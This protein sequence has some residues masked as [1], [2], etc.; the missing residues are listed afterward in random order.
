MALSLGREYCSVVPREVGQHKGDRIVGTERFDE[1]W[2]IEFEYDRPSGECPNPK[3]MTAREYRSGRSLNLGTELRQWDEPPFSVGENALFVAYDA[4]AALGCYLALGWQLPKAVLDL[5][6][7][8]KCRTAGLDLEVEGEL[9]DALAFFG[10]EAPQD[11]PLVKLF[12]ALL[13]EVSLGHALLRGRYTKAVTRMESVGVPI[14]VEA[15]DLLNQGWAGVKNELIAQVDKDF[16]V[17][18][19]GRLNPVRWAAWL[20]SK[21]IAWPREKNGYLRLDLDTF[22]DMADIHPDVGPVRELEATLTHLRNPR[23]AVGSD[24]RNRCPLRPFAAKTGRNQP[25]SSQ[26]IFGHASWLRG[27]IKPAEGMALA[28]VDFCQQEFGIAA[29][30]SGDEAM[31]AAYLSGDPYLEFAKQAKAIPP[32]GTKHSHRDF[33]ERFKR[34]AL[35]LQYGMTAKSLADWVKGSRRE[36]QD[37]IE[38]HKRTYPRYWRW[39][40]KVRRE[41]SRLGFLQT[42]FG[43]TLRVGSKARA[44]AHK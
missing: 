39:S 8:F 13:P 28:Y 16:V 14:D 11:N 44:S 25:R 3:G 37:L 34:S 2:L 5:H 6:A 23:L 21:H 17:Y 29:V 10:V 33:R 32:D 30:L 31:K 42:A 41:A 15:F 27:L 20:N 24:G 19:D 40:D 7:E 12:E 9:S 26:F 35:G 18:S 43:W 1:I 36:A 4:P 38:T 22:R